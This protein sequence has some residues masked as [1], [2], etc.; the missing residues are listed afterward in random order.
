[1][2]MIIQTQH[3]DGGTKRRLHMCPSRKHLHTR[4]PSCTTINEEV[5][6]EY[7]SEQHAKDD[8]WVHTNDIMFCEPGRDF[9]WVCPECAKEVKWENKNENRI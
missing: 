8:G 7:Y 5:I 3:R 9:V 2:E 1:M 6:K 4:Y